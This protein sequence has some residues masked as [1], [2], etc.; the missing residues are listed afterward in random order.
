MDERE[1]VVLRYWDWGGDSGKKQCEAN[2]EML[3]PLKVKPSVSE[4]GV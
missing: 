3:W 1:K 2:S 4:F